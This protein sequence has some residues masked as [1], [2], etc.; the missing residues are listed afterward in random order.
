MKKFADCV[1]NCENKCSSSVRVGHYDWPRHRSRT[2]STDLI[3]LDD[4]MI[5]GNLID[6][7][8]FLQPHTHTT[9]WR[10]APCQCLQTTYALER[11]HLNKSKKGLWPVWSIPFTHSSEL[12]HEM[13][14]WYWPSWPVFA[15]K[16]NY[17]IK[18][19]KYCYHN[20]C[21]KVQ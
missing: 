17:L 14:Q 5:L 1:I 3:R 4:R 6:I 15:S 21:S 18:S 20:A 13:F 10:F 11:N 12:A 7:F 19:K 9:F 2:I 16:Q 8:S